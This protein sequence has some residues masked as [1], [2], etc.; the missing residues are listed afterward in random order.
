[1]SE[2]SIEIGDLILYNSHTQ[3]TVGCVIAK[4]PYELAWDVEWYEKDGIDI[5]RYDEEILL[6]WKR[7]YQNKMKN[8]H[9]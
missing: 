1:M 5:G 4:A 3:P 6:E 8:N 9:G 2:E 7:N